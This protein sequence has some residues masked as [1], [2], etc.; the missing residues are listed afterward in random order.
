[1]LLS[2]V[3]FRGVIGYN[4]IEA[5]D[6]FFTF[7]KLALMTIETLSLIPSILVF[8]NLQFLFS[9]YAN[10]RYFE[11]KN[12]QIIKRIGTWMLLRELLN[13]IYQVLMTLYLTRY[14]QPGH[15]L[16]SISLSSQNIAA[17]LTAMI[18]FVCAHIMHQASLLARDNA[19]TI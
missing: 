15:H 3:I 16:L 17:I 13:P 11:T 12:I 1:M 9:E 7:D 19:L 6:A 5:P 18:I 4:S 14:N 2:S 8:Y 10:A